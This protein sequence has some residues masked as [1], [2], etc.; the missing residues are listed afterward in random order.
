MCI[1]SVTLEGNNDIPMQINTLG[2]DNLFFSKY[3]K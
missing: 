2:Y 3:N 1:K